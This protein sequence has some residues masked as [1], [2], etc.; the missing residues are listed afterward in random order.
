MFDAI[1]KTLPLFITT[2]YFSCTKGDTGF[3]QLRWRSRSRSNSTRAAS[4]W[5]EH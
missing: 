1:S 2:E 4:G 5:V 3:H